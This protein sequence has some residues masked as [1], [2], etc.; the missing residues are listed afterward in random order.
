MSKANI[1]PLVVKEEEEQEEVISEWIKKG[2][3]VSF[4]TLSPPK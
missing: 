3:I 2:L 1:I 4:Q